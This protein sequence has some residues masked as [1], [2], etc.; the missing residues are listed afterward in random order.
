MRRLGD[1]LFASFISVYYENKRDP[2]VRG[3]LFTYTMVKYR[4]FEWTQFRF[5]SSTDDMRREQI[6]PK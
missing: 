4:I 3:K 1:K 6:S 5:H 2:Y